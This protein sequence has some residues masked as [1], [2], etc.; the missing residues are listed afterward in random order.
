MLTDE[1]HATDFSV[2]SRM[3][4]AIEQG[5]TDT[6]RGCFAAGALAWHNND[7]LEQ[8]VETVVAIIGHLCAVSTS[9]VYEDRR[10]TTVGS[11]AFIQHTLTASLHSG[12][13]LRMPAMMRIVVNHDGLVER[14]EEY[15]DSRDV[16]CL[17]EE[18]A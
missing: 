11:Q 10:V 16:D 7:E 9:R 12:T 17:A 6:L 13:Q 14:I 1:C 5:D 8:D 2:V 4:D 3:L 18:T 15:L